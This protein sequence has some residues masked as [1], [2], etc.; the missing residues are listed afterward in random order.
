MYVLEARQGEIE[1]LAAQGAWLAAETEALLTAIGVAPG[2]RCLDL[3]C[4]LGD[5]TRLMAA[6]VG[7]TGRVVG[8]DVERRFLDLARIAAP[9][10]VTYREADACATGLPA[11]GF[12]LVHGRFLFAGSAGLDA[13][14]AE[15]IR[16]VRPGGVVALQE[17]DLSTTACH[18]PHPAFARLKA[19]LGAGLEQSGTGRGVAR[20]LF[21]LLRQAGLRAPRYHP[22]LVSCQAGD[23]QAEWLPQTVESLRGTILQAGLMAGPALDQMIAECRAHLADPG[24]TATLYTVVQVWARKPGGE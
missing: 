23:P 13:L 14:L 17:Q 2:W 21:G 19:M 11:E 15:A 9:A 16:L 3:A 10:T 20:R 12:D 18:P 7:A 22:F 8:V 6:R 1:R 24:T 5:V 4:G